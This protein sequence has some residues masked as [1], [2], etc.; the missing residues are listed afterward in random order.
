MKDALVSVIIP[1]FGR[2]ENLA[3]AINSVLNQSY[4]NIEIIIIDDNGEGTDNQKHTEHV[5]SET[6]LNKKVRY[7]V[8][9]C[10]LGGGL[11]RNLGIQSANGEYITFLDDDDVYLTDKVSKQ[12]RAFTCAAADIDMVVIGTELNY[13]NS[14]CKTLHPKGRNYREFLLGGVIMTPM[15]ML[16]REAF[17]KGIKF[18]DISRMQDHT[19]VLNFI[20][21]DL[22]YEILEDVG[23]IHNIHDGARITNSSHSNSVIDEL[24][25]L[26]LS[27]AKK[28]NF[29]DEDLK[30]LRLKNDILRLENYINKKGYKV[31]TCSFK[32][33][34]CIVSKS[35]K[36][37]KKMV[38]VRLFVRTI[39]GNSKYQKLRRKVLSV[40]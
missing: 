25:K 34:I 16:K 10:N 22:Q 21:L 24:E 8:S 18:L 26:E 31:S 2:P 37:N 14:D 3:K 12:V 35:L 23:Y 30:S 9:K 28:L 40:V 39:L 33:A 36:T 27:I 7:I 1:T 4:K 6:E 19:F 32:K 29:T 15:M 17:D 38:A 20:L 13:G 5:L 11:A